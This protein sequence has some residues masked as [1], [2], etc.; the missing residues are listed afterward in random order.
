MRNCGLCGNKMLS[1]YA[2]NLPFPVYCTE[3]WLS[4]KWDAATYGR[5]YDW[6]TPFFKQ[7]RTLW[8]VVPRQ[9][10]SQ[11]NVKNSPF[12]GNI[13]RDCN[14][15]YLSYS[16]IGSEEIY[17]SKD[18][19]KSRI[20]FDSFDVTSSENVYQSV[21]SYKNY[22]CAFAL[23]SSNCI[24]SSFLYECYNCRNCFLCTNLRNKE[25]C[26]RNMPRTKEEY[27]A[28]LEKLDLGSYHTQTKLIEEFTSLTARALH[29][30]ASLVNCSNCTGDDLINSKNARMSFSSHDLEDAAYMWRA[31]FIKDSMDVSGG[32]NTQLIYESQGAGISFSAMIRFNV[33]GAE[34]GNNQDIQYTAFCGHS[35]HLFGCV[36]MR[37]NA[38]CILNKQY[39]QEKYEILLPKIIE[40]M[41][42]SPY[43]DQNGRTYQYG[44]FFPPDLSPFGYNETVAQEY[45]TLAEADAKAKGFYWKN[46]GGRDYQITKQP[47]T[48]PDHIRDVPDKITEDIIGCAHKGAC[49]EQCTTAFRI[50][51]RELQFYRQ[52]NI[53]LPRLCPNCR[54]HERL[55]ERNPL[56]L[57]KRDC[58]CKGQW[59]E[60]EKYTNTGRH[61]HGTAP[62]PNRFQTPYAPGRSEIVYCERCYQ[63]EVV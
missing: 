57:W 63:A 23:H 51:P 3:C 15:V 26:I 61:F 34:G 10:I 58:M 27:L 37:N 45:F 41:N 9:N 17:Y 53:P 16:A 30:Y 2:E 60:Q 44:E 49:N 20:V 56:K 5:D 42:T 7:L 33:H 25:F 12:A 62:C 40:H 55:A 36:G 46:E 29:K 52:L 39:D 18:V 14:A 54:H 35:S 24:D 8:S 38:H 19:D 50:V 43:Q 31:P 21:L 11:T 48:L 32:S 22:N 1:M 59:S 13:L 47:D 6:D 4:D 28:E